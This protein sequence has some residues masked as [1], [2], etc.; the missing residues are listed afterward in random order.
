[1][2]ARNLLLLLAASALT[3]CTLAPKYE[4]PALPVP[5]RWPT[6]AANGHVANG[7]DLAWRQVFV[8]PRLAGTIDLALANN[9]DLRV[10][11]LNIERAQAAY[12]IQ[13]AALA[14]T[15]NAV[16]SGSKSHTPAAASGLP[17]SGLDVLKVETYNASV[18][19]TAYE[20]DLFGRV[21]SLKNA[22]LQTYLATGENARA[23]RMSLV[24][25]TAD[26]WLVLCADL[27]RLDLAR[28]TLRNREE[29]LA[30]TRRQLEAGTTSEL[31]L[32]NA[33]TL[34]ETA[35]G[36]L[37][38]F[39]AQV[40]QD[41]NALRLL[42][43]AELPEDLLPTGGITDIALLTE[44]PAGVTSDVLVRRPDVRAAEHQLQGANA[45]IGAARAA[46]LPQ[47]RLTGAY[48]SAS[49]DLDGLFKG[50]T[51]SW[52]FAPTATLPIFAGGAN[53]AA[54]GA[55]KADRQIAVA[56]YEKA[57]QTAFRE[58]ADALAVRDTINERL[59][60]QERLTDAA[61]ATQRLTLQ[62]HEAGLDSAVT[63]LAAQRVFYAAQ[64]GLI[65]AR[66][67]RA[68]NLVSLYKALGGGAPPA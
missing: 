52:S 68:Q 57:I 10:A 53:R 33:Q 3:G 20:L 13:R 43:G 4:R 47:I 50:G 31:A 62:R 19:V 39:T 17:I 40:E 55:A 1:M 29:G 25:A 60:A 27:D 21:Q 15:V 65:T 16:A 24:A 36:D 58:V 22:A 8:D 45:N 67:A 37:A 23:A 66:L 48:G 35:A 14:P 46:F 38:I 63:G 34:R 61:A 42:V 7:G 26:A 28:E 44:L 41:K 11:V 9:R 59:S 64:Q 30:F 49:S 2:L 51:K 6:E 12:R 54:L 56:T 18:G 32:R 5:G